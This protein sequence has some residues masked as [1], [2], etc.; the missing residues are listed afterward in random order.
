[1]RK[2]RLTLSMAATAMA[3][4]AMAQAPA[5]P[6]AEGFGRYTTGGRGGKIVHVTNLNDSGEGSLRAAVIGSEKKTVV[7]DVGGIIA[8][9]S[10][11]TI[12]GNT[13]IMGQTAPGQGIT[14]RYRTVLYGGDNIIVRF[15]RFR[16]GQERDVNDGADAT[17]TRHHRNIILDHCSFSWSIDEVASFYDNRDFTMQWCTVAE[18]L[19]NAGHNKGAHGYG[20]IWGGKGASFHHNF[21]AHLNNRSPRF[22]GARYAWDGYD[23]E[24]YGN[25]VMGER[26]DF[27]NCVVYNWGT[28]GCY[29]GPG[30]GFTNMV[31]N[32]YKAGPGTSHKNRVTECSTSDSG[33]SDSSHPEM[34]GLMSRYYIS[35][36]YVHGYGA[37]YDWQGVTY[38]RGSQTFTDAHN[39][40]GQGAGAT[41][42]VR[43]DEPSEAG[44][45]TTHDAE[46][47]F[48]KVRLYAGASL[49]RDA[50]DERYAKEALDGTATYKGS[51]TG[52]AGMLDVV[53][54]QGGYELEAASRPATSDTDGDGIPDDW[55]TANDL[56]P[57]NPED[58]NAYTLDPAR[59]YTN[60]E[61]YANSLVQDIMIAG[62][63]DATDP[64]K[65]YYPAYTKADGTAVEA[66]NTPDDLPAQPDEMTDLATGTLTWTLADGTIEAATLSADIE[67]FIAET[68]MEI[69]TNLTPNGSR[70][71][72]GM[73]M[74]LLKSMEKQTSPSSRN[75][76]SFAFTMAEG[77][78]FTPTSVKVSLSRIGTD[79]GVFDLAWSSSNGES[80][81]AAGCD[82]NRNKEANGWRTDFSQDLSGILPATGKNELRLNLY[83][84]NAGKETAIASIS[85]EGKVSMLTTGITAAEAGDTNAPASVSYYNLKGISID[86]PA[87][88]AYIRVET[89]GKG[90]RTARKV[91]AD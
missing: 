71:V 35:G 23:E 43:L 19:N 61:I 78:Y 36:N 89:D 7:F 4:L 42:N 11:L 51:V 88:G 87:R 76:V 44:T 34:F 5:F 80:A 2:K 31:N 85:I 8:L 33:N 22:N 63:A 81:I 90:N 73:E 18:A 55:E 79:S 28:G 45:V 53:A 59:Y 3:G 1:M 82:I 21:L 14:L 83:N 68:A 86:K 91:M 16:R 60:I 50:Q 32:Y 84:V 58:A 66:I 10:D 20:G 40:Y 6:G 9:E 30:G 12:G 52:R 49:S 15:V 70:D 74:T 77:C 29:G 24:K 25:T 57:N 54:D 46:T 48:E 64:V 37:N 67:Q 27:R 17:W 26:V 65:E 39:F 72:N 56:D 13:T 62:N 75:R 38:D 47:A 69:G 41:V